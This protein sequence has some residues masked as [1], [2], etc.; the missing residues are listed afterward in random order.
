MYKRQFSNK[1]KEE[2]YGELSILLKSGINL[3]A[4]LD[5][6]DETQTRKKQRQI[7][8]EI[9][10]LIVQG[11]SLHEALE[12]TKTFTPYEY[13]AVKIGEQTG[14]LAK[15][16]D[17]LRAYFSRKNELKRQLVSSLAYPIIVLITAFLA[18]IFMLNYVVP[19]FVDVFKQNNVELP[20]LTKQIVVISNLF[21]SN[22]W[23]LLLSLIHI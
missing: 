18:V 8:H 22:G 10:N 20:W 21:S 13:H 11:S 14:Q 17:D 3:K 19:M 15:I 12:R 2:F 4:A 5:L 7:V 16:T 6:I 1:A 23:V 9:A